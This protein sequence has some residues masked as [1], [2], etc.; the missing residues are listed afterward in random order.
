MD[1]PFFDAIQQLGGSVP[2]HRSSSAL[3]GMIES[4]LCVALA[5]LL[6]LQLGIYMLGV[7]L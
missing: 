7:N 1:L 3:F 6:Q 4:C 5:A 2:M